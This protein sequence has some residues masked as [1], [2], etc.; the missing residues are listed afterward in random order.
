MVQKVGAG[1]IDIDS[2]T[3]EYRHFLDMPLSVAE[4]AGPGAIFIELVLA[5]DDEPPAQVV[6]EDEPEIVIQ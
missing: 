3:L 2:D 5:V 6:L 1:L 4:E